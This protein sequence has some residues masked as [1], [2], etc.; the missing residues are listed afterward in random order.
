MRKA[1]L[2]IA[3]CFCAAC[4][5]DITV[6][7]Q[8]YPLPAGPVLARVTVTDL[9]APGT[10]ASKR[11]TFG[12]P[13]GNIQFDPPE[14]QMVKGVLEGELTKLLAESGVQ[15]P[16]D[17]ACDILEF[18][19]NT[20]TTP[21]YWDIIGRV[22]LVVKSGRGEKSLL[23]THTERTYVWPGEDLIRKVAEESLRQIAAE[24]KTAAQGL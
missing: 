13:M 24:L 4:V 6:K 1:I 14:A 21:L 22:R 11:E 15:T 17:Y 12:V 8:P 9:R 18:G 23:G 3:V 19:V 7:M 16:R 20:N 2:V 5:S 10:A